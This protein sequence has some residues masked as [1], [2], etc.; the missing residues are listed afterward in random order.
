M[1]VALSVKF[2][3]VRRD[4]LR[5]LGLSGVYRD[6]NARVG[7]GLFSN[8]NAFNKDDG[9]LELPSSVRYASLLVATAARPKTPA[10]PTTTAPTPTRTRIPN[11]ARR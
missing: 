1:Q 4:A 11:R 9:T 7:T 10:D 8:D 3:E 2:A 5:E 6:K